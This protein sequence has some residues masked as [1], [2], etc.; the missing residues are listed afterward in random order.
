MALLLLAAVAG[1]ALWMRP[2]RPSEPAT[3]AESAAADFGD[4]AEHAEPAE[5]TQRDPVSI[6]VPSDIPGVEADAA[7]VELVVRLVETVA[8]QARP[9]EIR[10]TRRGLAG[11]RVTW[12]GTRNAISDADGLASFADVAPRPGTLCVAPQGG[13]HGWSGT[14]DLAAPSGGLRRA[15]LRLTYEIELRANLG[16][17]GGRLLDAQGVPVAGAWIAL[18]RGAAA[19][20][21]SPGDADLLAPAQQSAADGAFELPRVQGEERLELLVA[22]ERS[23]LP[24]GHVRPL[25]TQELASPLALE[26]RL[27]PARHVSVRVL[28]RDGALAPGRLCLQRD[29]ALW[30]AEFEPRLAHTGAAQAARARPRASGVLELELQGG[31]WVVHF[32]PDQAGASRRL[33]QFTLAPGGATDFEFQWP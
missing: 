24:A 25:S 10:P 5:E 19:E 14:L 15:G 9:G 29:G 7:A 17:F 30:P 8:L 21:R 3:P 4:G 20:R 33:F 2:E 12:D 13:L 18:V 32:L 27:P 1:L 26:V 16:F 6:E 31:A 23:G 28:A 11:L 22:I